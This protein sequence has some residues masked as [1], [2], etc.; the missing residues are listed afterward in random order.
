MCLIRKR[1][2]EREFRTSFA[3]RFAAFFLPMFEISSWI[4]NITSTRE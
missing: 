2:Q 3:L 4:D 1:E